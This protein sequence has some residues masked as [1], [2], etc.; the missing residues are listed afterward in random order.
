MRL[1]AGRPG[2]YPG[3]MSTD[4]PVAVVTGA[5]TGIGLATAH[6]LAKAG[7]HVVM[8]A[9]N[10]KKGEAAVAEVRAAG[11]SAEPLSLDLA[12]FASVR[13]AADRLLE[14]H[15]RIHRLV[16]NAGLVL[17]ERSETEDGHESTFQIN[18]LGHFLLTTRL[19]P[20][21][22][23]AEG[24]RIVNLSSDGHR[25][26]RGL[27]F[28]DLM[29]ARR[30]YGGVAVYGDSKLA[31]ILFTRGLAKR[32]A[33]VA[34]AHAVHPGVV[35]T[36]FAGDGDA[37]GWFAAVVKLAGPF[38]L[39]PAKGA[40]TSLHVAL[41]DDAAKTNGDYWAKRKRRTPS[42]PARREE[43]AD[44]LWTVSETLVGASA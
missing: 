25:M 35:R 43:D 13:A 1:A 37:S 40:A 23:A 14:Q 21:L 16:N 36:G 42:G 38:M 31:N 5:N 32:W 17:T 11:G 34:I 39:T 30:S 4:L 24:C 7:F 20:A 26:S 15:P 33:D 29:Y 19:R 41:S 12:S 9:R 8:A 27:D 44:R 10:E 28:D 22:E 6:G 18:H 3:G 2:R